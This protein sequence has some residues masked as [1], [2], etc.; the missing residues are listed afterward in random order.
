MQPNGFVCNEKPKIVENKIRKSKS[1]KK[2][3]AIGIDFEKELKECIGVA[4][5]KSQRT[6]T[7]GKQN[8]LTEFWSS[9]ESM[10][11]SYVDDDEDFSKKAHIKRK[12]RKVCLCFFRKNLVF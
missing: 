1:Y 5:R 9:D 4:S 2:N 11:G 3:S 8:V 7:S 12:K 6:C 10:K